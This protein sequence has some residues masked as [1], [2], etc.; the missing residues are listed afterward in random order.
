MASFTDFFPAREPELRDWSNN[1]SAKITATPTAYGLT[2]A[3]AT[4]FAALNT[5]WVDAYVAIADPTTR[6]RG[7]V[8]TKN[9]AK[10]AMMDNARLLSAIVQAAPG[11]T[12]EQK[13]DL[14]LKVRGTPSPINPPTESPV[15]EVVSI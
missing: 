13:I 12:D 15:L 6:T 8:A 2:A 7:K 5:T 11:V 4:T 9:T 3:Q 10:R 1:F 14:G